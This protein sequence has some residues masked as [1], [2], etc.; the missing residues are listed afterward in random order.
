MAGLDLSGFVGESQKFQGLYQAA[1][2]LE[3]RKFRD[4]QLAQQKEGRVAATSKFLADYLDPKDRLTGTN[5]DP[6]SV[7][8]LQETLQEGA[9]LASKGAN[10]ADIMMALGPRVNKINEYS[11]KAKL[12]N[13]QIK[14]SLDKLKTYGGYNVAALEDEA[15]KL[16]FQDEKGGLKDISLVDP[17]TD[18]VTEA[19]RLKPDVVTTAAGL[20]ELVKKTPVATISR[21]VVTS[22]MGRTKNVKYDATHPW[23]MDL[24]RD[25]Q[26]EIATD[27]MGNPVGLDI[28]GGPILGDDN[29]PLLNPVTGEAF[30]GLGKK[31]FTA[32]MQHNPDIADYMRGQINK[33]F[34]DAGAEKIPDEGS[35]QWLAM[36]Q[37]LL[38]EELRTRDRSSFK[39]LEDTSKVAAPALRVE[40]GYPAYGT[41]GVPGYGQQGVVG[42]AL[43]AI[44]LSETTKKDGTYNLTEGGGKQYLGQL[45]NVM[46]KQLLP[47]YL[48]KSND[49]KN[50]ISID[51]KGG[52]IQSI[53][54]RGKKYTR[55]EIYNM[56][57]ARDKEAAKSQHQQY[58]EKQESIESK[59]AADWKSRAKKL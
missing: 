29:K 49:P 44:P 28:V 6:E 25:E 27:P 34:K 48:I 24:K 57:L 33:Y 40:M 3:R 4:D 50:A 11:T 58:P 21:N 54:I 7:R 38:G 59:P 35:P 14:S 43:N 39:V 20:D 45:Q 19:T 10:T 41:P 23:W 52:E 31:Q 16:A 1:E 15:K 9:T 5:Y 37:H 8:Q 26:G 51:V 22:K 53:N 42:N 12:V 32:I 46:G 55:Q 36:G 17:Q 56:Q 13:Q 47:D 2:T 18:W 30:T